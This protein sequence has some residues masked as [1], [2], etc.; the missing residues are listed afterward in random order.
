[1]PPARLICIGAQLYRR[2]IGWTDWLAAD[3]AVAPRTARSWIAPPGTVGHRNI[4]DHVAELL[5]LAA[6]HA[7]QLQLWDRQWPG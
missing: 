1:M 3:L 2:P 6:R 4:P 7:D 5:E